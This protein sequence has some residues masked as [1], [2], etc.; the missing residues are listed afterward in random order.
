MLSNRHMLE[1]SYQS[2][3]ALSVPHRFGRDV[4]SLIK[5]LHGT[6]TSVATLHHGS[7]KGMSAGRLLHIVGRGGDAASMCLHLRR[8]QHVVES[9]RVVAQGERI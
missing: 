2:Q 8:D 4:G 7:S 3:L 6:M 9:K 5:F 1:L